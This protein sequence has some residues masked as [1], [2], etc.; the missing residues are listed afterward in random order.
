MTSGVKKQHSYVQ[1][2]HMSGQDFP[3]TCYQ[4]NGSNNNQNPMNYPPP[5]PGYATPMHQQGN[6]GAHNSAFASTPGLFGY[7]RASSPMN[8]PMY[9][10]S[11]VS[12]EKNDHSYDMILFSLIHTID[13]T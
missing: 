6:T 7:S 11:N 3:N 12:S 10:H 1:Q 13:S 9:S 2:Q 5:P 4:I 8:H